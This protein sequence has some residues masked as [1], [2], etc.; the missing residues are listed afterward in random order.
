[1]SLIHIGWTVLAGLLAAGKQPPTRQKCLHPA[2][3]RN[4]QSQIPDHVVDVLN[5]RNVLVRKKTVSGLCTMSNKK[6]FLFV[7]PY[8]GRR[9]AD[10]VGQD[11]N[12]DHRIASFGRGMRT[13]HNLFPVNPLRQKSKL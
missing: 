8:G 13:I 3:S 10:S 7:L 9:Q 2:Y 1:L 6:A 4:V 11:T 5:T 12:G